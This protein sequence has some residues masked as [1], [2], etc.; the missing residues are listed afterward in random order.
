MR[1]S[2]NILRRRI[3][4]TCNFNDFRPIPFNPE[5]YLV[6]SEGYIYSRRSNKFLKTQTC[7]QG[8]KK[9]TLHRDKVRKTFKVHRLVAQ[10][11]VR[12]LD[13]A[14]ASQVNHKDGR[15]GNNHASNLEWVTPLQNTTHAIETGLH[16]CK[17]EGNANSVLKEGEVRDIKFSDE[18]VGSVAKKYNITKTHVHSIRRGDRWGHIT[19]EI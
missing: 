14:N 6:S 10:A 4:I 2:N 19:E 12:N 7:A 17:G 11:F 13:T 5:R 1:N 18:K 8:Y 9:V 16:K 3:M 15:K